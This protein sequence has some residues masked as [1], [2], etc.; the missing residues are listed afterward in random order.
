MIDHFFYIYSI[1][2][3]HIYFSGT[4]LYMI[5]TLGLIWIGLGTAKL[6]Y[7]IYDNHSLAVK[8]LRTILCIKKVLNFE[9]AP[10]GSISESHYYLALGSC[11]LPN[12]R[13]YISD[14]IIT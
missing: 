1:I 8:V 6:Y 12:L 9:N 4:S 2:Q 3:N 14:I 11:V 13:R 5:K 7:L 10:C